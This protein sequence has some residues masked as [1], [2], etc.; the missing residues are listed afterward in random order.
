MPANGV[1]WSDSDK[2]DMHSALMFFI[3]LALAIHT[4]AVNKRDPNMYHMQSWESLILV[5]ENCLQ[6]KP[7]VVNGGIRGESCDI[8]RWE[9]ETYVLNGARTSPKGEVRETKHVVEPRANNIG[10]CGRPH[11]RHTPLDQVEC[12]MGE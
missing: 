8:R 2:D 7:A 12:H 6:G 4:A 10:P 9:R 1:A 3:N 5:A 11:G